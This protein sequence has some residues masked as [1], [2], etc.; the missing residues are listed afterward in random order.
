MNA[1]VVANVKGSTEACH[2]A[3]RARLGQVYAHLRLFHADNKAAARTRNRP[4]HRQPLVLRNLEV[5]FAWV[6]LPGIAD[7]VVIVLLDFFREIN[8]DEVD[9][10]PRLAVEFTSGHQLSERL[11]VNNGTRHR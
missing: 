7:L 11:I 4:Y 5:M 2:E 10:Q 8:A 9:I 3:D 1:H 6:G